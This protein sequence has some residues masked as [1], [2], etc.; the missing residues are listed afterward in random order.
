MTLI[1][2]IDRSNTTDG[3]DVIEVLEK[4]CNMVAGVK[5]GMPL[6]LKH[7][8]NLLLNIRK[9]CNNNI[10]LDLKLADIGD[11]MVET[12]ELFKNYADSI[13]AHSFIG[14]KDGIDKLKN[15]LDKNNMKLILVGSMSHMGSE[16]IY[17]KEINNII[18][19][20]KDV[21][22]WGVVLPAT[23]PEIIRTFRSKIGNEIKILSPGIGYQGAKPGTALCYGADYEIVGRSIM[24][25]P[26]P[27][28]ATKVIIYEQK[29][30]MYECKR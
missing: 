29:R 26:D 25:A 10:I 27:K 5:L 17:D 6:L 22:P 19:I 3:R 24:N 13:I 18:N 28:E 7:D 14:K 11:I 8:L 20:I 4:I 15:F 2:A 9:I 23:R 12:A 16:E 30:G 21:N 1:V